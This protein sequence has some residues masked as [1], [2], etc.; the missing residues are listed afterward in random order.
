M[1]DDE[2]FLF[3]NERFYAA[4]AAGD[5]GAM[6]RLWAETAP[7]LCVHP[8]AAPLAERPRI[9]ESWRAILADPGVAGMR[10]DSPRLQRHGEV[11]LVS[12]YERLGGSTL[13]ALNGFVVENGTP[14]MVL[15]QAGACHDAPPAPPPAAAG[16][17]PLH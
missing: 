1:H 4:F 6:E 15:H 5:A 3:A 17:A 12:C 9:L 14:R 7:L 13:I 16:E 10:M 11:A 8:G 2:S